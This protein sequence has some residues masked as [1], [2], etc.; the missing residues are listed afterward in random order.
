MARYFQ[1]PVMQPVD[2]GYSMPFQEKMMYLQQQQQL[3]DQGRAAVESLYDVGQLNALK[4]DYT[5][6]DKIINHRY[7]ETDALMTDENGNLRDFR[8]IK[9]AVTAIARRRAKE[10]QSGGK[11][12]A[13]ANNYAAAQAYQKE[14]EEYHKK[15]EI[16]IRRKDALISDAFSSYKGIGDKDEL[17]AYNRFSGRSAAKEVDDIQIAYDYAKDVAYQKLQA[18]GIIDKNGVLADDETIENIMNSSD[19][20]SVMGGMYVQSGSVEFRTMETIHN[21]TKSALYSNNQ[22]KEDIL[23]EAWQ[24]GLTDPEQQEAYYAQKVEALAVNAAEKYASVKFSP[25]LTKNW[26]LEKQVELSNAKAVVDYEKQKE[27]NTL[28]WNTTTSDYK[29]KNPAELGKSIESSHSKIKSIQDK[30]QILKNKKTLSPTDEDNL[31]KLEMDLDRTKVQLH[32]WERQQ[33][34][35]GQTIIKNKGKGY[36][37]DKATEATIDFL[38][39]GVTGTVGNTNAEVA[40]FTKEVK[41]FFA[42]SGIPEDKIVGAMMS[43]N[44]FSLEVEGKTVGDH[45]KEIRDNN[46]LSRAQPWL[47]RNVGKE[48][49]EKA[50]EGGAV[51]TAHYFDK[52][53]KQINNE[54]GFTVNMQATAQTADAGALK[55]YNK[56]MS[57]VLLEGAPDLINATTGTTFDALKEVQAAKGKSVT[58]LEA[59]DL[60]E[61]HPETGMPMTMAVITYKDQNNKTQQLRRVVTTPQ[62]SNTT[63]SILKNKRVAA[64]EMIES[65]LT[66]ANDPDSDQD[67]AEGSINYGY[68]KFSGSEVMKLQKLKPGS[69]TML[70]MPGVEDAPIFVNRTSTGQF[71]FGYGIRQEDGSWYEPDFTENLGL[72]KDVRMWTQKPGE[73]LNYLFDNPEAFIENYGWVAYRMEGNKKQNPRTRK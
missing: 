36:G 28:Q 52:D 13:I 18:S 46:N 33:E 56:G 9:P 12:A 67:L 50:M 48:E 31:T 11:W 53:V 59:Y 57:T 34:A 30:I 58:S 2:Y 21:I 25:N 69:T 51:E 35:V 71:K 40:S 17:G 39:G 55:F 54:G 10:E 6:R 45:L 64:A 38:L 22:L 41:D 44:L 4:Q 42:T 32:A 65:A 62:G 14:I 66:R 63:K 23:Q 49:Y 16:G 5:D 15:G 61:P 27:M 70:T 3:Q 72:I 37:V 20:K 26:M 1:A 47:Y 43:G 7:E 19:F 24:G 60:M 73:S 68:T 29:I 8:N